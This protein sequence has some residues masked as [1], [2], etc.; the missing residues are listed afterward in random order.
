[1]I[2][3]RRA[4]LVSSLAALVAVPMFAQ[5]MPSEGPLPTSALINAES[6]NGVPL[7]PAMLTLEI[8]GHGTP[9][10]GVTPVHPGGTQLAILIDDGLRGSFGLQLPDLKKFIN[11]LPP[12][13]QVMVGY[14]RNGTV[15]GTGFTTDHAA[16]TS[17]LRL[18]IS[19]PGVD[20][21]PYFCLS[22]ISKHWPSNKPAARFVMMITNG[23]DPY[24]GS[25]SILNQDSPYVQ[26]A[27]EDA[28]RA[29]VAV[30]SIAFTE[31]G[32]RGRRGSFSGQSYLSQVAEATGGRSF[33]QGFGNP[34]SLGP[35]LDDFRKAINESYTINFMANA[36]LSKRDTLTRIKV[37]TS[38]P[39]VKVHG[40]AGVHPGVVAE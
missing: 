24:N 4:L 33:Y 38:Q 26:T 12:G 20:S 1:M 28:Q 14:M 29:G 5:E 11:D 22:E 3:F 10:T 36:P 8:N 23:V 18:P 2:T 39:G 16:A 7:D 21:S 9:L 17:V 19:A 27:Q 34:V 40:P 30:Y 37:R 31:A 25:T 35:F 32:M 6:K 13:V 15:Q